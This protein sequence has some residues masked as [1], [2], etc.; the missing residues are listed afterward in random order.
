MTA[1]DD[2]NNCHLLLSLKS[3]PIWSHHEWPELTYVA[4]PQPS[5]CLQF[6]PLLLCNAFQDAQLQPHRA[7]TAVA[8][9]GGF[10]VLHKSFR[11]PKHKA[12]PSVGVQGLS[13]L[14]RTIIF[15]GESYFLFPMGP[16]RLTPSPLSAHTR[17]LFAQSVLFRLDP[18]PFRDQVDPSHIA[19]SES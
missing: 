8:T 1:C 18:L 6:L 11:P 10:T 3:S 9:E 13:V 5:F 4:S 17:L 2:V 14:Q 16:L 7:Q 19:S 12:F 15:H